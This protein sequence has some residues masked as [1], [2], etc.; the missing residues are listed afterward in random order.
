MKTVRRTGVWRWMGLGTLLSICIGCGDDA[1]GDGSHEALPDAGANDTAST[2]APS[3]QTSDVDGGSETS[4]TTDAGDTFNDADCD[5]VELP[6]RCLADEDCPCRT[7]CNLGLCSAECGNDAQCEDGSMCSPSGRCESAS[8]SIE[9]NPRSGGLSIEQ[10]IVEFLGVDHR[11]SVAVTAL[12]AANRVRAV[13]PDGVLVRCERDGRFGTECQR[14][15][16]EVGG[17]TLLELQL[18]DPEDSLDDVGMLLVYAGGQM[19]R[20]SLQKAPVRPAS[21]IPRPGHYRGQLVGATETFDQGGLGPV[22]VFASLFQQSN[23]SVDLVVVDRGELLFTGGLD[24]ELRREGDT[25]TAVAGDVSRIAPEDSDGDWNADVAFDV[26]AEVVSVRDTVVHLALSVRP[27]GALPTALL[28]EVDVRTYEL[29]LS[30]AGETSH[31]EVPM[32]SQAV[33]LQNPATR[34][35]ASSAW[36]ELQK[37]AA[38][39]P[40]IPAAACT[41]RLL[42][43]R[44]QDGPV[45]LLAAPEFST[46]FDESG[47]DL[48]CA[49]GES[50]FVGVLPAT[51]TDLTGPELLERCLEELAAFAAGPNTDSAE[52]L[53]AP[54]ACVGAPRAMVALSRAISAEGAPLAGSSAVNAGPSKTSALA[55]QLLKQWLSVH[56]FVLTEHTQVERM[57]PLL[58]E[59]LPES[60]F[61]AMDVLSLVG[62]GLDVLLH[63]RVAQYLLT[64]SSDVLSGVDYRLQ[65]VNEAPVS[66]AHTQPIFID[67]LDVLVAYAEAGE[68]LLSNRCGTGDFSLAIDSRAA[69]MARHIR[70][71]FDLAKRLQQRLGSSS[72]EALAEQ[73][74][75]LVS[76]RLATF[77]RRLAQCR[78]A[79]N[80]L[81]IDDV[82]L[83]LYF[84]DAST[85]ITRFSAVSDYL[86][87]AAPDARGAWV[88]AAINQANEAFEDARSAWL[89]AAERELGRERSATEME[90]RLETIHR[91]YGEQIISLCGLLDVPAD[92]VLD[93]PLDPE[94]CFVEP[95]CQPDD[96]AIEERLSTADMAYS[97]CV[98]GKLRQ[99][100]GPVTGYGDDDLDALAD[101]FAAL[102]TLT[103]SEPGLWDSV[104]T[105]LTDNVETAADVSLKFRTAGLVGIDEVNQV[106]G[107]NYPQSAL[108]E[109]ERIEAADAEQLLASCASLRDSTDAARRPDLLPDSCNNSQA[110]PIGFVCA[111]SEC[112]PEEQDPLGNAECYRGALGEQ[113]LALESLAT[114]VDQAKS[115]YAELT[116]RYDIAVTSCNIQVVAN[117]AKEEETAAHAARM[118]KLESAKR[119]MDKAANAIGAIVGVA[120]AAAVGGPLGL[121]TGAAALGSG[122][123]QDRAAA[124]Q[125]QID[126]AESD[127]QAALERIQARADESI[128]FNDATQYLV[129]ARSAA[130]RI[131]RAAQEAALGLLALSNMKRSVRTLQRDGIAELEN[132]SQRQVA[133]LARDLWVDEHID[134]FE[135]KFHIA[136]RASYMAVRAVEYEFQACLEQRQAVIRA[137]VPA[138]LDAVV[139]A[140]LATSSTRGIG[141]RRP[142]SGVVVLSLRR[143]ILALAD[144]TQFVGGYPALDAA[145]RMQ[146]LLASPSNAAFDDDG[147]Y[148]GQEIAFSLS[149]EALEE[150]ASALVSGNTCAERLWSVTA[151]VVGDGVLA[152]DETSFVELELLKQNTFYSS[153][154][155][156]ACDE[157]GA[158]QVQLASVRPGRNLFRDPLFGGSDGIGP[159]G[160]REAE[161]TTSARLR[162]YVDVGRRELESDT[163]EAGA[164][165]ELA[166][167][168]LW[169]DYAL[170][171]PRAVIGRGDGGG[172]ILSNVDD[173]LLRLEYVSVAAR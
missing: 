92:E 162:A 81:G 48:T 142:S 94:R 73:R 15:V 17:V 8:S 152:G 84:G 78:N 116:E 39:C 13:A 74:S 47:V 101:Q 59:Q 156:E 64:W 90:R 153:L 46:T 63:P 68:G 109:Y 49:S 72:W 107:R 35:G 154:C 124:V 87:G 37:A 9:Q 23:G 133:S 165:E 19:A 171:V 168:G 80:P 3:E 139:D 10:S 150:S 71:L 89:S 146:A 85:A 155:P 34:A 79:E 31:L 62:D 102:T 114:G 147:N 115:E 86:I 83:P 61:D 52:E 67:L 108:P 75:T 41:E 173:I 98:A 50:G 159:Q 21:E 123:A 134:L 7:G 30:R 2:D 91:R 22:D 131:T 128:C 16:P 66:P 160:T 106:L 77:E 26:E 100:A 82:D 103:E 130:L 132:E 60:A 145:E 117:E 53:F 112:Q 161:S 126:Q 140:L 122:I 43:A 5:G 111:A 138:D 27:L 65:Y 99:H 33:L 163:Y 44:L 20:V 110:C 120:Q 164:S 24:I 170:L 136:K 118:A 143:D 55:Q 141:G 6:D 1:S 105:W 32:A 113:L 76:T 104:Q 135:R 97:L 40:D 14:D 88:P 125:A 158:G 121:V 129:G 45:D 172:L 127:H 69:R 42:C 151:S 93:V 29:L 148:L 95:E 4:D 56:G 38:P 54:A 157:A 167:R 137:S 58:A 12:G 57:R 28:D 70:T 96:A 169:G 149:P 144:R 51:V 25:W 18:T 36:S 119:D 11:P 166:G